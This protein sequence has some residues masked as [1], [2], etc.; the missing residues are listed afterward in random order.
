MFIQKSLQILTEVDATEFKSTEVSAT[1][2]KGN[3]FYQAITSI[4]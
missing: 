1:K 2:F 3:D 4:G